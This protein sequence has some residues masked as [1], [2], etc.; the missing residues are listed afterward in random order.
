M[1]QY[2][3][4]IPLLFIFLFALAACSQTN[5]ITPTAD[6]PTVT[7]S[8]KPT[9][10]QTPTD[11]PINT[12][13]ATAT[14]DSREL[15]DQKVKE[16]GIN[17]SYTYA[18]ISPKGNWVAVA[19]GNKENQTLQIANESGVVNSLNFSDYL[20]DEF[21][22]QGNPMGSLQPLH[23]T[24]DE[25]YLFFSPYVAY[26]GGGTCCY[27]FGYGGLF[28]MNLKD[29]E[30]SVILPLTETVDGYFFSFSP[31]GRYL[32]YI[33]GN[34]HIL[35]LNSGENYSI[36]VNNAGSGNL[37][38]SPGSSHFAFATC[39][40]DPDNIEEITNSTI[41]IFDVSNHTRR[42]LKSSQEN[43]LSIGYS[44]DDSYILISER[45]ENWDED[46][47]LYYWDQDL[48]IT[49]TPHP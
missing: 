25:Q 23:W 37:T 32:A 12:P 21:T 16:F 5:G 33:F 36:K 46:F 48:L 39:S 31:N 30:I 4:Q 3:R 2:R 18:I 8:P 43:F 6:S 19:C 26:D 10:T 38:W 7:L 24:V 41:Q 27:G 22:E 47:S 20:S 28:R 34:P 9:K 1:K 35:D 17:C 29:A 45:D 42:I 44:E 14:L 49:A 13:G 11:S 40:V 15:L